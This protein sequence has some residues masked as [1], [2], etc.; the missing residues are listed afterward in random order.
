VLSVD[1]TAGGATSSYFALGAGVAITGLQYGNTPGAIDFAG[2][3][4]WTLNFTNSS[5]TTINGS[6]QATGASMTL[7]TA[8]ANSTLNLSGHVTTGHPAGSVVIGN[9]TS[10]TS[11][12]ANTVVDV[13]LAADIFNPASG[14]SSFQAVAITPTFEGT[15]SGST[16]AL[17]VNPTITATNLSGTNLIAD[18]QSGGT[19]EVSIDYSGN[20]KAAGLIT[21]KGNIQLGVAGTT[22]GVVTLEGSTSGSCTITAPAVAG[23]ATNPIAL[24]NSIN[25][26]GASAVYQAQGTSGVTQT[27]EAVGTI[28]T[29]GGIVTTFTAVSDERLK[30]AQPYAGGLS[31][32]LSITPIKY[33]WNELGSKYSGQGTDREFVG[34]S[35]QNVRQQIPEAVWVSKDDYLGFDD[36]PVIAALVNAVKELKAELDALKARK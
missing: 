14:S 6:L 3:S 13:S 32:V 12:T 33:R 11:T 2:V 29:I 7:K 23:T 31:E 10:F 4:S 22:S 36:R 9:S 26:S 15:S 16:W 34:F 25:L 1:H 18:F 20:L 30:T 17:I 27:A 8:P 24:S 21:A 19:S 35:A 28:A 5:G